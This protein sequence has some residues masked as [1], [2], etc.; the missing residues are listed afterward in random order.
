MNKIDRIIELLEAMAAPK[1]PSTIREEKYRDA[2]YIMA[3]C[4]KAREEKGYG[5]LRV[6]NEVDSFLKKWID[7]S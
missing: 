4:K 2:M 7:F 1:I 5:F 6:A 3:L